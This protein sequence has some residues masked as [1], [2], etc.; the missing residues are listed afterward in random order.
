MQFYILVRKYNTINM[1][2]Y[3]EKALKFA[4][5]LGIRRAVACELVQRGGRL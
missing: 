5:G 2:L 4:C 3:L 1:S